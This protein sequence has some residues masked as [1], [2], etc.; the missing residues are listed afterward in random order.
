[1]MNPG[2]CRP[3]RGTLGLRMLSILSAVL[4]STVR[5]C[6]GSPFLSSSTSSIGNPAFWVPTRGGSNQQQQPEEYGRLSDDFFRLTPEQIESFHRDGCVTIDN[7]LTEEEVQEL[8]VVFDRFTSGDIPVPGKDFCDMSKPFGTPYSEWSIVNCM[9]PTTY[10]PPLKGNIYERLTNSMAQQL[11]SNDDSTSMVKDYDQFLNKRPGKDDAVFAW[12]Q[13]MAYWPGSK[14]L[15]GTKTDTCTFSLAID[16]SDPE[17]GCLRY[18]PGSGVAKTLRPHKP[19]GSDR[20]ETHA[21]CAQVDE[22]A[23]DTIQLAPAK[24]GS[25]TIHNEWVVHGSGGNTC[26]DRQRRTYV[27]AY[28]TRDTVAAERAIGFSHSHNDDVNWDTFLDGESHRVAGKQQD[29]EE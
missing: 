23:G 21:L 10:Y 27:V 1:M 3:I 18:I 16:D 14:A 22:T 7:V 25:V 12:H 26:A 13:D 2:S 11:F 29:D 19:L 8:Q 5:E 6:Q 9:L 24:R 20:D 4:L 17:N 28:R 15:G